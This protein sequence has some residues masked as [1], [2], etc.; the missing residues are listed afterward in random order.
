MYINH[1]VICLLN[2]FG[3]DLASTA[4]SLAWQAKVQVEALFGPHGASGGHTSWARGP[5]P[6][7]DATT[8]GFLYHQIW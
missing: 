5:W 8:A 7:G 2:G 3:S 6:G 1:T 4:P